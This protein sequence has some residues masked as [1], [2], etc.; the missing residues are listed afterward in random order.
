VRNFSRFAQL[1]RG[2]RGEFV[3]AA[4]IKELQRKCPVSSRWWE[5]RFL[6]VAVAVVVREISGF[7]GAVVVADVANFVFFLLWSCYY[8]FVMNRDELTLDLKNQ[9]EQLGFC[10]CGVC[11]AVAPAG[12]AKFDEWLNSGYAGQMHYLGERREAY[13][14]PRH[15][16]AGVRSVVMLAM[17]YATVEVG[18]T[19]SGGGRVSRYA[20]GE[21]DYHS[22]IRERLHRLADFLRELVPEATTRGVVDTA[23]LLER[24]FAQLAGLGWVGKNTLLLSKHAGSYFFLAALLTDQELACDA[25]HATD[26]C[27][28]CTACLDA[29]PT[30]AFVEPYVLDATRCISY[31]TIELQDVIPAALRPGMGDWVFGCDVCQDVCPWN[32]EAP[33]TDEQVFFP[34]QNLNPLDLTKLFDLD[35]PAF[36]TRF[37][38]TPLWRSHRRG[39]LRN[40]AI[41]LG[42]QKAVGAIAALSKGL[43]DIEPLVRGASAWALGELNTNDAQQTLL[44]RQSVEFDVQVQ[45]EISAALRHG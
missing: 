4:A 31:L 25:P 9:A 39:L 38:Q 13:A 20:W 12:L 42:N 2:Q 26:H 16:L 27:G 45:A 43:E 14:H 1:R 28:T 11:P 5:P 29:C 33:T 21:V 32:H 41:V 8:C 40:A 3:V 15:V 30:D 37:R 19:A 36:R 23:P 17:P 6:W 10:L 44:S 35:E 24:E 18:E 34:Q 7:S 22:V